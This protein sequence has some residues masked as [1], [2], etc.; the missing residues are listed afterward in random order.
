MD[1]KPIRKLELKKKTISRLGQNQM[2]LGGDSW[3]TI[4][5]QTAG[6]GITNGCGSDFTRTIS[7]IRPT[8]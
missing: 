6:C 5:Y 3:T 2:Q 4:I 1:K 7:S 8:G